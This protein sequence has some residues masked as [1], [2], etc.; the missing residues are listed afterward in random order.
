[1]RECQGC[2]VEVA[3][4]GHQKTAQ[5]TECTV[6]GEADRFVLEIVTVIGTRHSRFAD[7]GESS[8]MVSAP[9]NPCFHGL[10]D[11]F[12]NRVSFFFWYSV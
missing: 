10:F 9:S 5:L 11:E 3:F 8:E 7:G 4:V 1:M 12:L 6:R 2:L